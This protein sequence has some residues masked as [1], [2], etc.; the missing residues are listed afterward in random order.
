MPDKAVKGLRVVLLALLLSNTKGNLSAAAQAPSAAPPLTVTT[1]KFTPA[2]AL[3]LVNA[4]VNGKQ[5]TF[6]F[7]TGAI[8]SLVSLNMAGLKAGTP[9]MKQGK[10]S[11]GYTGEAYEVV[12]AIDFAHQHIDRLKVFAGNVDGLTERLERQCDGI[13]GQDILKG[14]HRI[15]IDYRTRTITLEGK[16]DVQSGT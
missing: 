12:V 10:P 4:T 15:S 14:F 8:S 2:K 1:V 9:A 6:I 13:I 5:G 11:D 16:T 7:D 3:M